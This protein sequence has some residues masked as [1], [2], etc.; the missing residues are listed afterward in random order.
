MEIAT[1][2]KTKYEPKIKTTTKKYT[3]SA[4]TTPPPKIRSTSKVPA[5]LISVSET[6]K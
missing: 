4:F 5:N 6:D 2:L 1:S 3:A